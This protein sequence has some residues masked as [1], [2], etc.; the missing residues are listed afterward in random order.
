MVPPPC[1]C[2]RSALAKNFLYYTI[3]ICSSQ[4]KMYTILHYTMVPI[5]RIILYY[6]FIKFIVLRIILYYTVGSGI[7]IL[8]A[9]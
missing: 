3:L 5:R 2:Q 9:Y 8:Y 4:V 6:P 7:I 1:P